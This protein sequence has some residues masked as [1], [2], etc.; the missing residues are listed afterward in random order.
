[1]FP[2]KKALYKFRIPLGCKDVFNFH[3]KVSSKSSDPP[4]A[5]LASFAYP[6][7]ELQL[8]LLPNT[9]SLGQTKWYRFR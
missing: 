3:E 8:H 9:M 4:D 1:M 5:R 6:N 2:R 7:S